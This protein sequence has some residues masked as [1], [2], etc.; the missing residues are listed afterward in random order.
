MA[1]AGLAYRAGGG[2]DMAALDPAGAAPARHALAI[3]QVSGW[4]CITVSDARDVT[5]AAGGGRSEGTG[6]Q[7]ALLAC[8]CNGPPPIATS[9]PSR[10]SSW[11]S[12]W[13]PASQTFGVQ[14]IQH[15]PQLSG[16]VQHSLHTAPVD[17]RADRKTTQPQLI[18]PPCCCHCGPVP[19]SQQPPASARPRP[20]LTRSLRCLARRIAA[21]SLAACT[22][23]AAVRPPD[24]PPAA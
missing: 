19:A 11:R 1:V 21:A 18:N 2:E 12:I 17:V 20:A 24:R 22:A 16:P 15:A 14:S 5:C 7:L 3:A 10:G 8:W 9:C 13:Q 23:A 6:E 4:S